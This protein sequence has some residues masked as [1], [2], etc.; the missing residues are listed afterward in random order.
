MTLS[1]IA[2]DERDRKFI[3]TQAPELLALPFHDACERIR[4][5][6]RQGILMRSRAKQLRYALQMN[7]IARKMR[8]N[9]RFRSE[10][11]SI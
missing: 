10:T 2:A 7:V 11:K 9:E 8:D 1:F 6:E 5:W 4:R 3:A